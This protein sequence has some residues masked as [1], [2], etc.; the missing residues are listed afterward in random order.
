M[1]REERLSAFQEFRL[2]YFN[3]IS[4]TDL[5]SRGLDTTKV[6]YPLIFKEL[7]TFQNFRRILKFFI[8]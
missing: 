8:R 4:C 6:N 1:E 3:V 7:F 5:T 2:G